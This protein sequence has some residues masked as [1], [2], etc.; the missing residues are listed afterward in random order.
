MLEDHKRTGAYYQAVLQN[1]RKFEGKAVLDVGTGSGILAIFAAKA[2]AR[3]V[4]AVEA[5]A[6]A[7]F[8]AKLVEHNQLSDVIT[9]IQGTMES[10]DLPEK[11]DIIISEWMGYFLLRES[12]LDSVLFARDKFLVPGGA[13][14]PSHARLY[15]APIRTGSTQQRLNDFQACWTLGLLQASFR[16]GMP[17]SSVH[18]VLM[19]QLPG[20]A[21]AAHAIFAA[22]AG[23]LPQS[24]APLTLCVQGA[25]QGWSA[26][27][28][29][30]NAFYGVDM[31]CLNDAFH[32]EQRDYYLSTSAWADVHP[33]QLQGPPACFKQY[34]LHT[35]TLAEL[36]APLE[37]PP[38]APL[39][40]RTLCDHPFR[41]QA[42]FALDILDSGN[43][44]AMAGFFDVQF[45]GSAENPADF[46]VL[47]ST[48]PDPTGSTHWGQQTFA[49]HPPVECTRG[50]LPW[51]R[52]HGAL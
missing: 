7:A 29:E 48:A 35:L 50:G 23:L 21:P 45:R 27:V 1:R 36:A 43:I 46:D 18:I 37:H 3:K 24:A 52:M 6:M 17:V 13:M 20:Q 26:F 5:T 34:D 22:V 16:A 8:A 41:M 2:G 33:S 31:Q 30:V 19:L 40:P 44:N 39:I 28:H 47:L 32:Q 4:Y 10:V 11:V 15:L 49:L 42:S 9:V 14:Y 12:M 25:M 51:H 38:N